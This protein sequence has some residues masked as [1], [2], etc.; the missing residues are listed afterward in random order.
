MA[1][2]AGT[3]LVAYEIVGAIGA[4]GMSGRRAAELPRL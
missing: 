1:L 4:G 3:R 2:S